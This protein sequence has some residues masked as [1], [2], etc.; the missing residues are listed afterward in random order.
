VWLAVVG[1]ETP[2]FGSCLLDYIQ[3][4]LCMLDPL[5]SLQ[6]RLLSLSNLTGAAFDKTQ[7]VCLFFCVLLLNMFLM[8]IIDNLGFRHTVCTVFSRHD[9]A[10]QVFVV[11]ELKIDFGLECKRLDLVVC[12]FT[13]RTKLL[14]VVF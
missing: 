11:L 9:N 2:N 13:F 8:T 7:L 10:L 6:L 4:L 1:V 12:L 14:L 3:E 5:L